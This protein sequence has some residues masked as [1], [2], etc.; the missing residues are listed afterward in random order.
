MIGFDADQDCSHVA[1]A[2]YAKG[3]RFC[4]RY[5]KNLSPAEI[6]AL[7]AAGL[8]IVLIWETTAT[9]ALAGALAGTVDG[10]LAAGQAIALG[11]PLRATVAIYATADFDVTEAQQGAVMAYLDAFDA[12]VGY[13]YRTGAYAN[14]A[15][16]ALAIQRGRYAWL[17]GGM[18]MRGS[19]AFLASGKATIVQSVGDK[20]DLDLGIDIDSD[21][22]ID[23]DI[24]AWLPDAA[25]VPPPVPEPFYSIPDAKTLQHML[26][27]AGASPQLV[28]DGLWGERSA[29]A[30]AAHYA[31]G[32]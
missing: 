20:A 7:H 8:A 1:V 18:G 22:A 6:T 26:N 5:L 30:L 29:A 2:A 24:G 13:S 31:T 3:A 10:H 11:V 12:T 21:T 9:R 15:I 32:G 25:V 17:A 4:C 28:E 27:V 23:G 14:G 16:C 19:A